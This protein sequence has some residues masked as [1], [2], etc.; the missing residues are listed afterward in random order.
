MEARAISPILCFTSPSGVTCDA[1][2]DVATLVVGLTAVGDAVPAASFAP[3]SLRRPCGE[4][5]QCMDILSETVLVTSV[6][7][8]RVGGHLHFQYPW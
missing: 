8:C 3:A 7:G 6:P 1:F 2:F 5:C 4:L